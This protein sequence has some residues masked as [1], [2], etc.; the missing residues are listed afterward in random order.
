MTAFD[1]GLVQAAFPQLNCEWV[2]SIGST[3]NAVQTNS[4]LIA[5]EQT[6]GVGRR[7]RHWLTPKGRS[8]SLSYRFELPLPT[9]KTSGYQ[10]TTALAVLDTIKH[11]DHQAKVQL[12]WPNDLY[13]QQK[14]F[15]GILINLIPKQQN[16]TE[17]ILGV[18]IN[19][20]LTTQQLG[21]I[22]RPITNIPITTKPDRA[23]FVITLLQNIQRLNQQFIQT[24]LKPALDRWQ[25]NDFLLDK[26]IAIINDQDMEA[27]QYAGISPSGELLLQ[28]RTGIKHL[29]SGE[30]SV[31]P[32]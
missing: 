2:E 5:D 16:L 3:Q 1:I 23:T 6:A 19:W 13:H 18:G 4:L 8:I 22:E 32:V 15:A 9:A 28:T 26:K 24:G 30:V 31:K 7:G 12:K 10:L 27:G 25:Q 14:K 11:F 29:S 21:T 20:Q 17:V